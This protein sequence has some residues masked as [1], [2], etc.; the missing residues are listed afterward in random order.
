MYQYFLRYF[1]MAAYPSSDAK[2]EPYKDTMS[3]SIYFWKIK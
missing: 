2:V 1:G 3:Y